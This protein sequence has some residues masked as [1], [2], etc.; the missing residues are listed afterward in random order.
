[1][2]RGRRGDPPQ[3]EAAKGYPGRRKTKVDKA[4][5]RQRHLAELL[6]AAPGDGDGVLTP[7]RFLD[8]R[9][10]A[11][12][13]VWR[14]YVP[15]LA[16][17]HLFEALDRYSFALFC[18]A[19]GEWLE[20][21]EDIAATGYSMKVRTVSGDY[22]PRENPSVSRREAASKIVFEMSKRF[23]L[24]PLDRANLYR[25]HAELPGRGGLFAGGGARPDADGPP[26]SEPAAPAAERDEAIGMLGRFDSPPPGTRTN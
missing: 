8:Q 18:V 9:F 20:A 4:I 19:V 3:V 11:A 22:M 24:T 17:I 12:L 13:A 2:A 15:R 7:P 14:D 1:M 21:N 23:G 5:E 16:K 25:S 10:A 6:A 26:A